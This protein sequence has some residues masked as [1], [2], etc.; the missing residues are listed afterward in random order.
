MKSVLSTLRLRLT[1]IIRLNRRNRRFKRE[2]NYA[3]RPQMARRASVKVCRCTRRARGLAVK[4]NRCSSISSS[5]STSTSS[6]EAVV[7]AE[8]AALFFGLHRRSE[9]V[10]ILGAVWQPE[11]RRGV[12]DA[13]GRRRRWRRWRRRSVIRLAAHREQRV[14]R[15]TLWIRAGL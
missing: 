12:P 1:L 2:N 6:R 4:A 11:R 8:P 5:R 15:G 10:S 9:K 3:P 14:A 7:S 13:R